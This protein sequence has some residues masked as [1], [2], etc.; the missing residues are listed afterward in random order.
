MR[1]AIHKILLIVIPSRWR[2]PQRGGD[3]PVV[4]IAASAKVAPAIRHPPRLLSLA[5]ATREYARRLDAGT[6][7]TARDADL[8]RLFEAMGPEIWAWAYARRLT[9]QRPWRARPD[10]DERVERAIVGH[11]MLCDVDTWERAL[12]RLD[13]EVERARLHRTRIPDPLAVPDAIRAVIEERRRSALE[14]VE[15]RRRR[16]DDGSGSLP[17]PEEAVAHVPFPAKAK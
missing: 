1:K 6:L 14:R 17:V 13:A 8:A 3:P 11:E 4:P 9:G 12:K 2:M 5:T 16:A 7:T 10:I 15:R